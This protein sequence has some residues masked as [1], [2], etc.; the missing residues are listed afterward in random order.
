[1]KGLRATFGILM[2]FWLAVVVIIWY[3]SGAR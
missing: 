2:L 3:A 1:M